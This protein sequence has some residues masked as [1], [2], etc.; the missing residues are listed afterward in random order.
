MV[1]LLSLLC[2]TLICLLWA[3]IVQT[4]AMVRDLKESLRLKQRL[5][6]LERPSRGIRQ[7]GFKDLIYEVN[8]LLSRY[9]AQKGDENTDYSNQVAAMFASI[10]EAIFILDG[11]HIIEFANES[12]QRLF[13]S[14][15]P[16]KGSRLESILRSS[17]ILEFLNTHGDS[18]SSQRRE[19]SVNRREEKLWFEASCAPVH[20][21]SAPDSIS[22]LLVLHDITRLKGLEVMRRDFV[23]NVSHELRTPLTII[24]G[25]AETLAEDNST[26]SAEDRIRFLNK[27]INNAQRL[28]LLVEDLLT[29]S[30]LESQSDSINPTLH[31]L[32]QLFEDTVE[33]YR[34]RLE[35]ESQRIEIEFDK[36]IG[37]FLFDP[38]QINQVIDNLIENAFRYAPEFT[39]LT[40]R[41]VYDET[42]DWV[43]CSV[44]DDGPG[45]PAKDLPHIF[46]RFYRVDKGRS[47]ERGG[48]GLGLSITKHIVQ[49]HR[50]RVYAESRLG[51]GTSIYF[52]LPYMQAPHVIEI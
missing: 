14:S 49:L 31:S 6:L 41:T 25:F 2:G 18:R 37:K 34:S 46:E 47:R 36:R 48:T 24:K 30:H 42:R 27:I 44:E 10:Q 39:K 13:Q 40:L 50:G 9:K 15:R 19:I 45:I 43:E 20:G 21:V 8:T 28:H 16:L 52:S 33:N 5:L 12:A 29:L 35:S 38:Y 1:I 26:L 51:E 3:Y 11:D 23:A 4:R 7:L 17:S 22:T 32:N